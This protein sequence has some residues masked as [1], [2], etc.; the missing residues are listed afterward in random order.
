VIR[1][2]RFLVSALPHFAGMVA[3]LSLVAWLAPMPEP[4]DQAMM[5][6]VG[7]GVIVPGCAD[8]NCFRILV[9]ATL[10]ALPGSSLV[11]WRGFAVLANAGA[12]IATSHLA[13]TLGMSAAAATWAGWLAA[14]GAGAFATVYHPY[15]ADPLVLL[16]APVITTQQMRRRL[17]LATVAATIGVF[18]K[19]FAAAPLYV[20]GAAAAIER[21]WRDSAT[22]FLLALVVTAVWIVLQITLMRLFNY[23]YNDNPSSQPL[24]GGYL[25]LWLTHVPATSAVFALF[26]AFGAAYVLLPSGWAAA[27]PR[28]KHLAIGSIPAALALVLVATPE[29]ALWN[30]FFLVLPIAALP[31]ERIAVPLAAL[32]VGSFAVANMRIGGQIMAVPSSRYAL[33]ITLA[34]AVFA[35]WRSRSITEEAFA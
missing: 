15:N 8:L 25:R 10:E 5:E 35:I 22:Q 18:A 26:S 28:L 13:L 20:A 2:N 3:M 30:F 1:A 9:P 23:S 16:L 17:L 11:R 4:T 14:T 24:A 34:I 12:A 31:L 7:R 21:R 29:R 19:E 6:R 33:A 32:F 27:P